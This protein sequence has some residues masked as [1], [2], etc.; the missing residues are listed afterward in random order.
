M[1]KTAYSTHSTTY[2]MIKTAYTHTP[3]M[4]SLHIIQHTYTPYSFYTAYYIHHTP[5]SFYTSH[6][7]RH[8]PYSFYASHTIRHTHSTH[9][10]MPTH[11][12]RHTH[13]T[14]HTMP[15]HTIRHTHS[16]HHT[17]HTTR[18]THYTH[19]TVQVPMLWRGGSSSPYE[20]FTLHGARLEPGK[21]PLTRK[22]ALTPSQR[23]QGE[24]TAL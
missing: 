23:T 12:I 3:C 4:L 7:P 19:H 22:G 10:T 8:T 6:N 16:T 11:T 24:L 13:S 17:T 5:C 9:H 18:H 15:T 20:G 2:I 1:I 14:H 21:E